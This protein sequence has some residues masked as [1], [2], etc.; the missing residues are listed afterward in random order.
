M[1]SGAVM[2]D[3]QFG[4]ARVV[5]PFP[6]FESRYQGL[7]GTTPIALPGVL[8]SLAGKPG[9][10]PNLMAGVPVPMG[11][12]L[13]LWFPSVIGGGSAGPGQ[14][15]TW[16]YRYEIR[17]RLRNLSDFQS[18]RAAYHFPKQSLGENSQFV[19]PAAKNVIL[20]EGGRNADNLQSNFV[21]NRT[22]AS[23]ESYEFTTFSGPPPVM[24]NGQL[25]ALE[26]GLGGTG[27]GGPTDNQN[28]AYNVI[29]IDA[30]GDEMIIFV[31]K[32]PDQGPW[33]FTQGPGLINDQLFSR[34]YGGGTGKILPDLGIYAFS[35]SNP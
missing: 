19:I 30:R 9:Y 12:K 31:T 16:P 21:S 4:A 3:A 1:T 2:A 23:V 20:F 29:D 10:D 35:G 28:A 8:D 6:G 34:F 11:S 26:Q 13:M 18:N 17:W 7:P 27:S 25:G 24:P 22:V 14:S 33:D 15:I 5:K 32:P